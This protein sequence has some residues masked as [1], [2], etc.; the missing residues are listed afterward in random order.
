VIKSQWAC[1]HYSYRK[2]PLPLK[3]DVTFV[4]QPHGN[5]RQLIERLRKGGIDVRVWGTGWETGRLSQEEMIHVFNQSR[6]NLNLSNSVVK[7]STAAERAK[8]QGRRLVSNGLGMFPGGRQIKSFG[9][10]LLNGGHKTA[11][12][13]QSSDKDRKNSHAFIEQIKGRNFEVPGCG[14]F[15]LTGRPE[16]LEDYYRIGNEVACY[17]DGEDL[18]AKIQ[19]FLKNEEERASIALAGYR[20]TLREHTYAHRF[21]AIFSRMNLPVPSMCQITEA[22]GPVGNV[23][24]VN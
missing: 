9:K 24:E 6:I 13:S 10:R 4:G 16:N 23:T 20:R 22:R 14:G 7:I 3:Y 12:A 19:Y 15:V 17:R 18:V 2:H 8:E 1:N 5:R 21:N 11:E